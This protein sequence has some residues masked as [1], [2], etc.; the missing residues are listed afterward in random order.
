MVKY[1]KF[2]NFTVNLSDYLPEQQ[3]LKY[4]PTEDGQPLYL[5]RS[6]QKKQ[7]IIKYFTGIQCCCREGH[8]RQL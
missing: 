1:E 7:K 2:E 4:T 3:A 6:T 5:P 8:A